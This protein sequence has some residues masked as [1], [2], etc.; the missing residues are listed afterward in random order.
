MW[1][2][3]ALSL[4]RTGRR[5]VPLHILE[6]SRFGEGRAPL[7]PDNQM[8]EHA[9]VYQREGVAQ[10][11]GDEFIGLTGLGNSGGVLGCISGCNRPFWRWV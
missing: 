10:P 5:N 3:P 1:S 8:I 6:K 11:L 9:H 4:G 7:A 2:P